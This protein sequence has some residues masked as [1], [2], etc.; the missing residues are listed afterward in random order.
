MRRTLLLLVALLMG[1]A[2]APFPRRPR[3]DDGPRDLQAMQGVW[4]E[5]FADSAAVTIAGDRMEYHPDHAWKLTLNARANPRRI[6]A[7]GVGPGVAGQVRRGIYRLEKG[8]LI[9]CWGRGS[10]GD[11]V[12]PASLDPF[13]KDLW[14][15]VFT[16]VKP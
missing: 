11:L 7:A 16:L 3:A 4:A 5:R 14:I 2:P 9:I 1:F 6:E 12:W 13:H 15:E 10:D 8:K